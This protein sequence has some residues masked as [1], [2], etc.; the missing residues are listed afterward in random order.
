MS[1]VLQVCQELEQNAPVEF[2]EGGHR[3]P[4]M[5]HMLTKELY[6][7]TFTKTKW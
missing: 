3:L 2:R 5:V 1:R 4:Y 7:H 6:F